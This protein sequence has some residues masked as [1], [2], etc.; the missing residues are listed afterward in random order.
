MTCWNYIILYHP[1]PERYLYG[2]YAV[3]LLPKVYDLILRSRRL[4][5]FLWEI[6]LILLDVTL[7]IIVVIVD[8]VDIIHVVIVNVV[9][10]IDFEFH[11]V[12]FDVQPEQQDMP[13]VGL[14]GAGGQDWGSR[15][16]PGLVTVVQIDGLVL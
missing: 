3:F 14:H 8:I 11:I 2:E 7:V 12:T 15:L 16:Q 9:F 4:R 10:R 5:G 13:I 6:S 1:I